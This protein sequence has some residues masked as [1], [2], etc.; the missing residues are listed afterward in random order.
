MKKTVTINIS[1]IIFHIDEDA[2]DRLNRYMSRLKRHFA[3]MEGRDEIISDIEARIAELLQEKIVDNKQV[4]TIEDIEEVVKILGEPAEMEGDIEN[5]EDQESKRSQSYN[6]T[7]RLYRDPDN[8]KIAGVSSGLATYFNIDDP[9]WIRLLFIISI[10]IS[11]AGIIAYVILWIVMPEAITTAEKLEM[12]GEPVNISNIERSFRDEFGNVKE[13]FTELTD[14]AKE[15][16]RRKGT[17]SK[18]F[19]DDFIDVVGSALRIILKIIV[20][21]IALVLILSGLGFIIA[22]VVGTAG[23]SSFSFFEHG[24]LVSFSLSTFLAMF[25]PGKITGVLSIISMLLLFGIPLI[26]MIYLGIR[27]MLGTRVRVPYIGTT[28]FAF[29]LAGLVMAIIVGASTGIDFRHSARIHQEYE[30]DINTD[31]ILY[32]KTQTDAQLNDKYNHGTAEI[33]DGEWNMKIKGDDYLLYAV[34]DFSASRKSH[35]DMAVFEVSYFAK[36][37]SR[38]EANRR[39]EELTYPVVVNDTLLKIGTYYKLP[40][41]AKIRAQNVKLKL[42]LPVGQIVHFDQDMETFFD[43]NPNYYYRREGFEGNTWIM[44]E[45]GLKPYLEGYEMDDSYLYNTQPHDQHLTLLLTKSLIPIPGF[46][47]TPLIGL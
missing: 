25:F 4:I 21:I 2:Y 17:R 26:M 37:S 33:F 44:T 42:K 29:W 31:K 36:G 9:L 7:K 3:K 13:K 11:G 5:D 15:T 18:T 41:N 38:K 12:R 14:G 40:P 24:E 23:L 16:I 30:I 43:D 47:P 27:L 32:I 28:A 39:A 34:P 22:F 20:V 46:I 8:R 45:T 10:F 6:R 1:G 35:S 19:F